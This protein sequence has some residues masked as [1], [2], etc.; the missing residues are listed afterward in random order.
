[1][2]MKRTALPKYNKPQG[3]TPNTPSRPSTQLPQCKSIPSRVEQRGNSQFQSLTRWLLH[4]QIYLSFNLIAVLFFIHSCLPKVRP[5]TSMFFSLS[6]HNPST[7]NYGAGSGDLFFL[8]LCVILFTGLRACFMEYLLGPL[9]KHWGVV[10]KKELTRFSEQA[11]LLCYYSIFWT[12]GVY[13]YCTS[14][15]FLAPREMFTSWPTREL[16]GITKTY[17]LG[18][19]A[20]WLQQVIVINIEER[21]KDHWQMLAHHVVTILLIYTSYTLHLTTVANLVLVLMDVVDIF[22]PIAKCLKYL[23][24]TTLRDIMFGVF[25]FSWF[26]ARHVFYILNLYHIWKYMPE[27]INPG[28]YYKS[29]DALIIGPTPLP[30]RGWS[31]MLEAFSN[32]SGTICYSDGIRWGFLGALG[33]LQVLTI[34]WFLLIVQV[35]IRVFK[36]IGADDIRSEDE[37]EDELDHGHGSVNPEAW[38]CSANVRG[39]ATSSGV[40]LPGSWDRKESLGR[41]GCVKH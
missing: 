29:Q 5:Y 27:T 8:A 31:H 7:G 41:I 32:P 17:I 30:E 16:P 23:G 33:F 28:C 22:F 11:W 10:K 6:H 13:I 39:N 14:D 15:Y 26:V 38:K 25:M 9:A 3:T 1:M 24:F 18:Q 4:N 36:G 34:S 40:G 12:L 2:T 35:A 19:C 37:D 21:R 20:F